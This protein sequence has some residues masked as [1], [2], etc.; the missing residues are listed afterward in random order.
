MTRPKFLN[1]ITFILAILFVC[2][3]VPAFANR[4]GGGGFHGGGG[5]GFRGGSSRGGGFS[6]PRGGGGFSRPAQ[7][8]PMRS[9]VGSFA[10]PGGG[11]TARSF[12]SPGNS[13]SRGAAVYSAPA[14][15]ADGRWHSFGNATGVREGFGASAQTQAPASG[16]GFRVFSGNRSVDGIRS[17]RSFSGQGNQVWENASM[18]RNVVSSS[19]TLSNMRA[20]FGNSRS[21][22]SGL[23]SGAVSS[24][25]SRISGS[26]AFGNRV[27]L[28]GTGVN[29]TAVFGNQFTFGSP[30]FGF[31]GG[32]RWG[33]WN[34]GFGWGFGFGWWPG[35]GFGWPWFGY[36]YWAPF[37]WNSL[38]WGWPGYYGYPAGYPY[39][40][41]YNSYYGSSSYQ[42]PGED[43]TSPDPQPSPAPADQ[44]SP[45]YNSVAGGA[46]PVLIYLKSG[47][48]F[49]AVDYWS[50]GD[51]IHY[52]LINGRSGAFAA[53]QLDLQ[54]TVTEN[55]K[56][57]VPF[58]L[59]SSPNRS[60]GAPAGSPSPQN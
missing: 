58:A 16:G 46:V 47:S 60:A 53:D 41:D 18:S 4:G 50:S 7:S 35:R 30:R 3:A 51:E 1:S 17:T 56:S 29:R 12:S 23:R 11:N 26:S 31:R 9:G 43:Y 42:A 6:A 8:A 22:A 55:N 32:N 27:V 39:G 52:V 14:A 36:S 21:A 57:G 28:G 13:N 59:S 34:C 54:R 40:Y 49:S 37:Y 38:T 33:C 48:V 2:S 25:N 20:S 45:Q 10:R 24:A 44:P 15:T 5:G 19:R